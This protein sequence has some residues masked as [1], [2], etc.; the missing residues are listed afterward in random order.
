MTYNKIHFQ[1]R[2][3]PLIYVTLAHC[4]STPLTEF[5]SG[6]AGQDN[7]LASGYTTVEKEFDELFQEL[8]SLRYSR[9]QEQLH[10]EIL[11]DE[12][13][14][15]LACPSEQEARTAILGVSGVWSEG[16]LAG[17]FQLKRDFAAL[18]RKITARLNYISMLALIELNVILDPP[19]PAVLREMLELDRKKSTPTRLDS[20]EDLRSRIAETFNAQLVVDQQSWDSAMKN[21]ELMAK[22]LRE[23]FG[24][25]R[26]NRTHARYELGTNIWERLETAVI[27]KRPERDITAAYREL[28]S[29]TEN[30]ANELCDW[31]DANT[32]NGNTKKE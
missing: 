27:T 7:P 16:T 31:R 23:N 25:E 10:L 3:E 8:S 26:A 24:L 30:L 20:R 14:T 18:A 11:R 21:L 29:Q 22:I 17:A 28:Q 5:G 15:F 4:P 13:E 6:F 2:S 19:N 9:R 12:I 1:S 32:K